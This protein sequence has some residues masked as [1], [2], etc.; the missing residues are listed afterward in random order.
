VP[1]AEGFEHIMPAEE[2]AFLAST[3][4]GA[5]LSADAAEHL[6]QASLTYHQDDVAERHLRAAQALAPDHAA[7]LIGLYRFYFYKGR[8]PEALGIAQRCV[9]KAARENRLPGDW[10]AVMAGD[11]EF[12][13]YDDMLPR[14]YLFSLKGYAYLQMRLG[15]LDEGR[16]AVMKLLDLDPTD[17]IGAKVLLSILERIGQ[18][19][20]E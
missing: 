18:N 20:D 12:S 9:M 11:A 14:F 1:L 13:R 7:V 4:L 3:L 5:G 17:K 8:L 16:A 15:N 19:D 2:Q 6:Y 10:R